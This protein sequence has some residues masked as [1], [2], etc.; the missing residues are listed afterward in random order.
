MAKVKM[1][2]SWCIPVVLITVV[3]MVP[4]V[5]QAAS[6]KIWPDQQKP[7]YPNNAYYQEGSMVC[8]GHF[9]V[10]LTLP[11]GARITKITYYYEGVN[12]ES[13]TALDIYRIKVGNRAELLWHERS[14]GSTSGEVIPVNVAVTGDSVFRKGYRYCVRPYSSSLSSYF[15]GVKIDYQE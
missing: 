2:L 13:G 7:L 1:V 6:I 11:A 3:L 12:S 9:Y 8:S 15:M 10:P 4:A 5:G 14:T